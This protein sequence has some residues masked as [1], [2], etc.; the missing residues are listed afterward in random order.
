MVVEDGRRKV[1]AAPPIRRDRL[2]TAL[3][4]LRSRLPAHVQGVVDLGDMELEGPE[5]EGAI[6]RGFL[7]S[8]QVKNLI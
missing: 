2:V 6:S 3:N 8:W 5:E 1:E 4:V 7:M